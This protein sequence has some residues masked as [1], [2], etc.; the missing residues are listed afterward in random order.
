MADYRVIAI[1]ETDIM[2]VFPFKAPEETKKD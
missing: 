1:T 2:D